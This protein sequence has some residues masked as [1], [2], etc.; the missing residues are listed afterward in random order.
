M[1]V[2]DWM[3]LGEVLAA[4][5]AP[6]VIVCAR[7]GELPFPAPRELIELRS[8]WATTRPEGPWLFPGDTAEGHISQDSVRRVFVDALA[9]AGIRKHVRPHSLRH[10]FATHLRELGVDLS[11]IQALLGHS[12]ISTTQV[13][14]RV[15]SARL[16]AAYERS[17]PRA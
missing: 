6:D 15:E 12:S 11:V 13:Y 5:P 8:Y 9:A 1:E 14:T 2:L 7:G 17:H 10:S 16:R 4:D 3:A